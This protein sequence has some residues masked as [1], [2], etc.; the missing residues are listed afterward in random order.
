M[1]SRIINQADFENI[2]S[3]SEAKAQCRV[4][5]EMDDAYLEALIPVAGE[6]AQS[7]SNRMLTLGSATTVIE[8]YQ[9]TITLPFGDVTA[10]TEVLLDGVVSTDFTFEP[11]TQKLTIN[12]AYSVAKVTYSCGYVTAPKVVKQAMLMIINTLYDTRQDHIAGLTVAKM[13]LTSQTLLDAVR[14]YGI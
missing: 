14:Y 7:Y 12:T 6:M 4:F 10:V 13:P 1:Y 8:C 9:S 11:V 2:V 3:L 5:H